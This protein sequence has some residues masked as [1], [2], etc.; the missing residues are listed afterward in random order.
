MWALVIGTVIVF[1]IGIF[2][3]AWIIFKTDP[4]NIDL[5]WLNYS[6]CIWFTFSTFIG[7]SVMR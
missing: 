5:E 1:A 4:K 6:S 7:E 2:M 3:I